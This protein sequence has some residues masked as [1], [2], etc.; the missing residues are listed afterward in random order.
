[1]SNQ[2]NPLQKIV[3]GAIRDLIIQSNSKKATKPTKSN[4][5]NKLKTK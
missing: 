3:R 4:K 2:L 5:S 1:M